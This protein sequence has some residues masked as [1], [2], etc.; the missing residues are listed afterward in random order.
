MLVVQNVVYVGD[1]DD[2][3]KRIKLG[4]VYEFEVNNNNLEIPSQ[5]SITISRQNIIVKANTFSYGDLTFKL[6]D[7]IL[8]KSRYLYNGTALEDVFIFTGYI[9]DY[10]MDDNFIKLS[11]ESSSYLLKKMKR[12]DFSLKN[13]KLADILKKTFES[14]ILSEGVGWMQLCGAVVGD[15][16]QTLDIQYED[17]IDFTGTWL[18][19]GNKTPMEIMAT[20]KEELQIYIFE[21]N[22]V[23]YIN[24]RYPDVYN[25]YKFAYPYDKD[26]FY[27]IDNKIDYQLNDLDSYIIKAKS[28]I[29]STEMI[30]V[31][32][33]SD[34]Y[35]E[36]NT[37]KDRPIEI[38]LPPLSEA[39]VKKIVETNW[40]KIIS[41]DMKTGTFYTFGYPICRIGDEVTLKID[42]EINKYYVD[43]VKY[44]SKTDGLRQ[45]ILIGLK[46]S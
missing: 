17:N 38:N 14:Y 15:Y 13:P 8:I 29:S 26:Y 25:K 16:E 4:C 21:F 19:E 6:F 23:I 30:K 5:A 41:N 34:G 7:R 33:T 28:T 32:Y 12:I 37:E 39:S 9:I 11:L 44:T 36:Y 3:K 31:A 46:V 35:V 1:I 10:K 2:P 40:D 45:D 24:K 18:T 43:G 27:I 42:D 20:L 22:G